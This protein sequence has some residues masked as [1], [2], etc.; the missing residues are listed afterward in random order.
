MPHAITRRG[1]PEPTRL[2]RLPWPSRV[3]PRVAERM[4]VVAWSSYPGVAGSAIHVV[5]ARAY[6][7][8]SCAGAACT[9][10]R[11]GAIAV[12]R[13]T[14]ASTAQRAIDIFGKAIVLT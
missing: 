5:I 7:R 11:V 4:R 8:V 2:T 10:T 12:R 14:R 9:P 3:K 6:D 1:L 13:K